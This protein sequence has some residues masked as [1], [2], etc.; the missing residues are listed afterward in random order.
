MSLNELVS[1]FVDTVS[2]W[3]S[4][5]PEPHRFGGTEFKLGNV[6]IGHIHRNNGM[7]DIPFTVK[8]R[9]VL[10]AEGLA[11]PH[12]LLHE[13]GWIT[14]F[15]RDESSLAHSLWLMRLSYLQKRSRRQPLEETELQNLQL[16]DNLKAAA[17]PRLV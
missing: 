16:S 12:H 3:E 11:Q 6:E 14:F 10:V 15:L 17:F 8:I 5:Q 2:Q 7:V 1:R 13:S 9:E 4:I